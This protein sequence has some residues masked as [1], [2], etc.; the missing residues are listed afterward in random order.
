[1]T[2]RTAKEVVTLR[3]ITM[4]FDR[5]VRSY[6]PLYT[7]ICRTFPSDGLD[8]K[9]V[10]RGAVAGMREWVGPRVFNTLRAADFTVVN[11]HWEG[12][13]EIQK[14]DIDDDRLDFYGDLL[15]DL[16]AEAAAKPDELLVDLILNGDTA[17][18]WDG[19]FFFDTDHAWGDSGSQSNDLTHAAATGTT[20]T[21]TEWKDSF[22]EARLKLMTYKNDQGKF[23]NRAIAGSLKNLV[24]LVPPDQSVVAREALQS[25]IISNSSNVVVD[26]PTVWDVPQLTEQPV[27]Y[28]VDLSGALRPFIFQARK[29]L[30]RQMKGMDDQEFKE[31]KFMCD[32]RYELAY[33]AWWKIVRMEFT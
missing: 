13:L 1:M 5:E 11:R 15:A 9:Y 30:R 22:H 32:A 27:Y 29:P 20:P 17:T 14:T 25:T 23:F 21:A 33:Y 18:T 26:A 2:L 31:V 6:V 24:V 28:I 4:R 19:Q 3:D 12:G 8:E 16:G 7:R 10:A